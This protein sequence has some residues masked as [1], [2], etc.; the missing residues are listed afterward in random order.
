MPKLPRSLTV[1]TIKLSTSAS[2][3]I[4]AITNI[5]FRPFV[6]ISLTRD[7]KRKIASVVRESKCNSASNA[8]GSTGDTSNSFGRHDGEIRG[9]SE[10]S[11]V[12]FILRLPFKLCTV[13]ELLSKAHL[14]AT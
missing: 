4:S 6:S 11:L 8:L 10:D 9:I 3:V 12:L 2:L 7:S 13:F 5:A 14:D 1:V